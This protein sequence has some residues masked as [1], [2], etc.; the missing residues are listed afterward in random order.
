MHAVVVVVL[1]RKEKEK[2]RERKRKREREGVPRKGTVSFLHKADCIHAIA[3]HT[4]AAM[5]RMIRMYVLDRRRG[6]RM[7]KAN[8]WWVW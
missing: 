4:R 2:R 6:S 7:R 3:E 5:D 1:K 8:V